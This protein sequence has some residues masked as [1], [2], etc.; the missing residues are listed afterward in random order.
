MLDSFNASSYEFSKPA[1]TFFLPT[2]IAYVLVHA[3]IAVYAQQLQKAG[4]YSESLLSL[5]VY[6]S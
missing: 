6:V 5:L 3:C 2:P 1:K 4:V